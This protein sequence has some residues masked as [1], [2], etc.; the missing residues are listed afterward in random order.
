MGLNAAS[1][2]P[3]SPVERFTATLLCFGIGIGIS[4][5]VVALWL[6]ARAHAAGGSPAAALAAGLLVAVAARSVGVLI[7]H[8]W[9][10]GDEVGW[11]GLLVGAGATVAFTR[12]G[13]TTAPLAAVAAGLVWVVWW[14]Q[15]Q[16]CHRVLSALST[17]LHH[18]RREGDIGVETQGAVF[19]TLATAAIMDLLGPALFGGSLARITGVFL[20][21]QCGCACI[22]VALVHRRGLLRRAALEEATVLPEFGRQTSGGV[23][24]IAVAAVLLGAVLPRYAGAVSG[25]LFTGVAHL[26]QRLLPSMHSAVGP[27]GAPPPGPRSGGSASG[28]L[29]GGGAG[30]PLLKLLVE[31]M[32][33]AT[34]VLVAWAAVRLL[35]GWIRQ[36]A[37]LGWPPIWQML[38]QMWRVLVEMLRDLWAS[39]RAGGLWRWLTAGRGPGLAAVRLPTLPATRRETLCERWTDPRLR[40]RTAYRR[41]LAGAVDRGHRRPHWATPRMF[42]AILGPALPPDPDALKAL[43]GLYEEAR[44]SPHTIDDRDAGTAEAAAHDILRH[45][46]DSGGATR[47]P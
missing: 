10:A 20:A 12:M 2:V 41:L 25:G 19:G 46:R 30:G 29:G 37:G 16:V 18:A 26:L 5:Q 14:L 45:L 34:L 8:E 24:A 28:A 1:P 11:V 7:R 13:P 6:G 23:L 36:R 39:L 42:R 15:G 38:A 47:R 3:A 32:A 44:Y 9:G 40:V 43:T 17:D 4:A 21:G 22:V 35:I 27:R 31:V 33:L